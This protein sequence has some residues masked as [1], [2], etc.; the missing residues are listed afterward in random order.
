MKLPH[1]RYPRHTRRSRVLA[2]AGTAAVLLCSGLAVPLGANADE[3][4]ADIAVSAGVTAEANKSTAEIAGTAGI[5]AEGAADEVGP[6]AQGDDAVDD[7]PDD[8]LDIGLYDGHADESDDDVADESDD[9][10]ADESDDAQDSESDDDPVNESDI[11]S[12]TKSGVKSDMQGDLD[13][14]ADSTAGLAGKGV[15]IE[16]EVKVE[17]DLADILVEPDTEAELIEDVSLI[18]LAAAPATTCQAANQTTLENT[19]F[20]Q[21]AT[22]DLTIILTSNINVTNLTNLVVDV[23]AGRNLVITSLAGTAAPYN[24]LTGVWF[25]V[26]GNL[27]I[28]ELQLGHATADNSA[29]Q[30]LIQVGNGGT[31]TLDNGGAL[32]NNQ[33]YGAIVVNDLIDATINIL[34]GSSITGNSR[35]GGG[36]AIYLGDDATLNMTGGT[37]SG[38]SALGT[39]NGGGILIS[40]A[41]ANRENVSISDATITNNTAGGNGGGIYAG[42]YATLSLTGTSV[43]GN[44]AAQY[45]GGVYTNSNS[46]ITLDATTI[47]SNKATLDGGGI[48]ANSNSTVTLRNGTSAASNTA[49]RNGGGMWLAIGSV[50]QVSDATISGNNAAQD[51]GGVYLVSGYGSALIQGNSVLAGNTAGGNGGAIWLSY[52]SPTVNQL[53]N[54][55]IASTVA[56]SGNSAFTGN[57]IRNS[58]DDQVYAK[59][60]LV[61]NNAW[62]AYNGT[63]LVQG[64]NNYDIAYSIY[65]NDI[66]I[67][68]QNV[69]GLDPATAAELNLTNIAPA[70]N[71]GEQG[72]AYGGQTVVWE[73]DS[74][75][76]LDPAGTLRTPWSAANV[77]V[78]AVVPAGASGSTCPAVFDLNATNALNS[79]LATVTAATSAPCTTNI[80]WTLG[81]VTDQTGLIPLQIVTHTNSIIGES[82]ALTLTAQITASSIIGASSVLSATHTVN[83]LADPPAISVTKTVDAPLD[84]LNDSQTFTLTLTVTPP[85]DAAEPTSI[86]RPV[87][88]DVFSYNGD[89][90]VDG[91]QGSSFS[92]QNVLA[93]APTDLVDGTPAGGAFYYWSGDPATMPTS[94]ELDMAPECASVGDTGCWLTTFTAANP[95]ITGI[96]YVAT[97]PLGASN[98]P[99]ALS[100]VYTLDQLGNKPG[101]QYIN[102]FVAYTDSCLAD[103]DSV[104]CPEIAGFTGSEHLPFISAATRVQIIAYALG[105]LVWLDAN[106]A[107][108]PTDGIYQPGVDAPAVGVTVEVFSAGA[109]GLQGTADDAQLCVA[110]DGSAQYSSDASGA[111][112]IPSVAD[113]QDLL[114][115]SS[116]VVTDANGRWAVTG[117]AAGTY[118]AV[119]P[120][121]MFAD[122]APLAGY[123]ALAADYS[124]VAPAAD[125]TCPALGAL[126]P[127]LGRNENHAG[128]AGVGDNQDG[129]QVTANQVTTGLMTLRPALDA[130]GT[131]IV[132]GGQPAG[133]GLIGD[134]PTDGSTPPPAIDDTFT[135]LTLDIA[136]VQPNLPPIFALPY[137]GTTPARL[138]YLLASLLIGL[139]GVSY[140][141]TRRSAALCD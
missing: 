126:C 67:T 50:L 89:I 29:I 93:S 68:A 37:I 73:L 101:D 7:D 108:S 118:Y 94:P 84:D 62:S 47:N 54:L 12:D 27:T 70:A 111:I 52:T 140:L 120:A 21:L 74:L 96:K 41:N 46:T 123:Q 63:P 80:T 103:T 53:A 109:D 64:Y 102:N 5:E 39:S 79:T 113:C 11:E 48:Y 77:V 87:F 86:A 23:P 38:N 81:T 134:A 34:P 129:V 132:G 10:L 119:L 116:S 33:N 15:D 35:S 9:G 71:V 13:A 141:K 122:G 117:L 139:A 127:D 30:P 135:N 138:P 115:G 3:G 59:N 76:T 57:I 133:V 6:A 110:A 36:G 49:S 85:P 92:G 114:A 4:S 98:S 137:A 17:S 31:F 91:L 55:Q 104:H 40:S 69:A 8:G 83:V 14:D 125:S 82:V 18:A 20:T 97:N 124:E 56:F 75:F 128:A 19:C 100:V 28:T 2:A 16:D 130:T 25:T 131:F 58:G 106:T 22:T 105:D 43:T 90:A 42:N 121:A 136:L 44:Q 51:G 95:N 26:E 99:S 66:T 112:A 32:Q 60:I 45:G 61:P 88:Y 78:S 107:G 72:Q 65:I 1:P 24:R